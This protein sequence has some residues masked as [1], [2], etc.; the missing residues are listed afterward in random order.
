MG[1]ASL[2]ATAT[3]LVIGLSDHDAALVVA[4]AALF[5]VSAAAGGS[6]VLHRRTSQPAGAARKVRPARVRSRDLPRGTYVRDAVVLACPSGL[7]GDAAVRFAVRESALRGAR[8]VVIASY[9]TPV[10]PDLESIETPEAELRR[11]ARTRAETTLCR[12][13]GRA[14]SQLPP[15]EIVTESG[16]AVHVLLRD[17]ADAQLIVVA[18]MHRGPL[19]RLG[20]IH[21]NGTA[22]VLRSR[23]PVAFVPSDPATAMDGSP[24]RIP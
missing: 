6:M 5:A 18:Q 22:L 1:L 8:L 9:V 24:E 3:Y 20:A 7:D 11:R 12:A 15:H 2:A 19:A 10:D 16:P 17:Y 4:A 14:H 13:L 21:A 23:S